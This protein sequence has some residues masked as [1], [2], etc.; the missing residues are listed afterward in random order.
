MKEAAIGAIFSKDR[1]KVLLIKRRDVPVWVLPGGGIEKDESPEN[2]C[3]REVLE[4]SGFQIRIEKKVGEY[5]PKNSLTTFTHLFRGEVVSGKAQL[6]NETQEVRFFPLDKLP[7]LLPPP[8]D[9]WITEAALSQD[10][11]IKRELTNITYGLLLKKFFSHPLLV[12]RFLLS[13]LGFFQT[14]K[15][16]S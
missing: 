5:T 15:K 3:I 7:K 10:S 11:L 16:S 13:K 12:L 8:H 2:T 6:S 14:D 4:E 1:Q 9:E